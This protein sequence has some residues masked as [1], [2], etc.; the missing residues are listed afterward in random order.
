MHCHLCDILLDYGPVYSFWC[1]SYECYN[2]ILSSQPTNNKD[3]EPQLMHRFLL[4]NNITYSIACPETF[5]EDF[6]QVNLPSQRL[7]GSL[8]S[9]NTL[10]TDLTIEYPKQF[11][12]VA[13]DFR[14]KVPILDALEHHL[15]CSREDIDLNTIARK[16]RYITINGKIISTHRQE[17]C[18]MFKLDNIIDELQSALPSA[19]GPDP[20]IRPCQVLTFL[21]VSY[22]SSLFTSSILLAHIN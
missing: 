11:T 4:D 21:K 2:G 7:T 6:N 8:L 10:N 17:T 12:R 14:G 16:Y 13:L 5:Y 15:S 3:I 9:S 22:T 20:T 19:S 1:F 18:V